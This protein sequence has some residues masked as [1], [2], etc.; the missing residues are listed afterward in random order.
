MCNGYIR[1]MR[2]NHSKNERKKKTNR[3]KKRR[4]A[5]LQTCTVFHL[6]IMEEKGTLHLNLLSLNLYWLIE[7]MNG[8]VA[9]PRT[10]NDN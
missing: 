7:R 4:E 6:N 1:E 8:S 2:V 9:C 10:F 3:K 5:G